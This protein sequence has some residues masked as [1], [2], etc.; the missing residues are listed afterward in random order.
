MICDQD[1]GWTELIVCPS[2]RMDINECI[3]KLKCPFNDGRV[4][5]WTQIAIEGSK[6]TLFHENVIVRDIKV[7]DDVR[8]YRP[9]IPEKLEFYR[10]DQRILLSD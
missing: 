7:P 10:L 4:C 3:A 9:D 5:S 8:M 2:K 1:I 6:Q